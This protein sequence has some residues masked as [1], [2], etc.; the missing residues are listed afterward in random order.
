MERRNSISNFKKAEPPASQYQ[1]SAGRER[2]PSLA[3]IKVEQVDEEDETP[4]PTAAVQYPR[5]SGDITISNATC[6]FSGNP[7]VE[8]GDVD[9]AGHKD[10]QDDHEDQDDQESEEGL[11]STP[12]LSGEMTPVNIISSNVI[13]GDAEERRASTG[14]FFENEIPE[15]DDEDIYEGA[16]ENSDGN[17]G[18]DESCDSD[19]KQ[20]Y[21]RNLRLFNRLVLTTVSSD[22]LTNITSSVD[23]PPVSPSRSKSHRPPKKECPYSEGEL[24]RRKTFVATSKASMGDLVRCD[25]NVTMVTASSSPALIR[26]ASQMA[27]KMFGRSFSAGEPAE[28]ATRQQKGEPAARQQKG[29]DLSSK[30]KFSI[31]WSEDELSDAGNGE[32]ETDGAIFFRRE[33]SS[34]LQQVIN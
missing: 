16:D 10:D 11:L 27:L 1:A 21:S 23:E 9:G 18:D 25:S 20:M 17:I 2:P 32:E 13:F 28:A 8:E 6:F 15:F 24:R 7:H 26:R 31:D 12:S 22:P 19:H 34:G 5:S 3:I 33:R 30:V 29:S 4:T 14:E